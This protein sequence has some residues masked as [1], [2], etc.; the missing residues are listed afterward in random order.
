MTRLICRLTTPGKQGS[1]GGTG[2][3]L[4]RNTKNLKAGLIV[5]AEGMGT[6]GPF[7]GGAA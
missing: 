4:R 7:D 1:I 2:F 6:Q 5:L 3:R